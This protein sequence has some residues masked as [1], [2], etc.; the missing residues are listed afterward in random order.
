H[1]GHEVIA[2]DSGEEGLKSLHGA[3]LVVTDVGMQHMNG[4]D[5]LRSVR[6]ERPDLPVVFLSALV[7]ARTLEGDEAPDLVLSK[8]ASLSDLRQAFRSLESP[9]DADAGARSVASEVKTRGC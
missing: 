4:L 6:R 1:L 9:A 8:P 3:D 7:E 2:A 5:V